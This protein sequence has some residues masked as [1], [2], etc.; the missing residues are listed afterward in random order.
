MMPRTTPTFCRALATL[1][2]F[3]I[4]AAAPST[5]HAQDAGDQI[6]ISRLGYRATKA[7]TSF[8]TYAV[9]REIGLSRPVSAI[10]GAVLPVVISKGIYVASGSPGGRWPNAGFALK[11]MASELVEGS[12]PAFM[13]WASRGGKKQ[14]WRWPVA[15]VGYGTLVGATWKW[16]TP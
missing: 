5:A 10:T 2:L 7:A 6:S 8:G 11:D 1:S 9:A 12:G 14:W 13:V 3:V 15:A 4:V 16:G